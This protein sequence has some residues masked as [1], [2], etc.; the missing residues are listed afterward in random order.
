MSEKQQ[1]KIYTHGDME[2][3][4][5]MAT[6]QATLAMQRED[7]KEH[8]ESDEKIFTELFKLIREVRT[9]VSDIP[10]TVHQCRDQL[11]IKIHKDIEDNFVKKEEFHKFSNKITFTI[12]GVVLAGM[13]LTWGIS[14][15]INVQKLAGG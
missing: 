14:L 5:A 15:F 2:T 6:V 7:F 13:F 3:A 12:S 9:E 10:N 11:E 1:E 8:T 4:K